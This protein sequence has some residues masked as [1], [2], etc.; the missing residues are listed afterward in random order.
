MEN[1]G[2]EGD[3]HQVES[4]IWLKQVKMKLLLLALR[5]Q[6]VVVHRHQKARIIFHVVE[7]DFATSIGCCVVCTLVD[8]GMQGYSKNMYD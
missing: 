1:N 7:E 4:L 2:V 5:S 3:M 8:E 6:A